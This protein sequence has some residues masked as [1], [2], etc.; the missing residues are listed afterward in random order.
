MHPVGLFFTV[1]VG[2]ILKLPSF[3]HYTHTHTTEKVRIT[4]T[5]GTQIFSI[6]EDINIKS[7]KLSKICILLKLEM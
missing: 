5:L 2:I 4:L 1:N 3:I 6:K 7:N